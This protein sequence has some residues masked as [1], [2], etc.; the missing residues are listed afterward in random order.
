MS[1]EEILQ[2]LHRRQLENI[3]FIGKQ[4]LY[5]C[6]NTT[7]DPTRYQHWDEWMSN[8]FQTRDNLVVYTLNETPFE[9]RIVEL[10]QEH[11]IPCV[12]FTLDGTLKHR[13]EYIIQFADRTFVLWE[14]HDDKT[15]RIQREAT[16][17]AKLILTVISLQYWLDGHEGF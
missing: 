14:S 13:Y 6:T 17:K 2:Q 4:I 3:S 1:D 16:E 10:C 7:H 8:L 9:T 11:H 15:S 5:L 12:V